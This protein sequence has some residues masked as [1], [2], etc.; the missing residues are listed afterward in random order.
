MKK[1]TAKRGRSGEVLVEFTLVGL[2]LMFVLIST[3]E[4]A[5]GMWNYDTLAFAVRTGA[6]YAAAH[7]KIC[8]TGG[9]TCSATVS[10]V[11]HAI[12]DAAVGLPPQSFSVV[13][14][15]AT[16]AATT[17]AP[18]SSCF[19]TATVWPPSGDNA[20]GKDIRISATYV[21]RSALA[22]F[23]PGAGK[24]NFG[25]FTLGAWTRQPMQ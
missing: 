9:N 19:S 13:L 16:A 8:T 4:M 2:P 25:I 21:F 15:P 10:S 18:V 5:R 23:W 12:A 24:V 3:F 7:G 1:R 20:P 6:R 14:T 17:C 11:A 22:M